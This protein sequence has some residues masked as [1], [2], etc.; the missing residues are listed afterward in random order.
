MTRIRYSKNENSLT[1]K[2]M[3]LGLDVVKVVLDPATFT[4]SVVKTVDGSVLST[5][6]GKNMTKTKALAKTALQKLG[7]VFDGEVRDRGKK[8][9]SDEELE[10]LKNA[11]FKVSENM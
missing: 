9:Y 3:Q 11:Q 4:Y 2:E 8:G 10:E 6:T 1:S 5:G 7:M